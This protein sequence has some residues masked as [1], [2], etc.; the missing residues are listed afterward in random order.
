MK[1]TKRIRAI[2]LDKIRSGDQIVDIADAVGVTRQALY[3]AKLVDEEFGNEWEE[4][5]EI[6]Q[7]IQLS[8]CE[9]ELDFRGRVGWI[10]PK[11]YE[12]RVCGF[13]KKYSDSLLQLRLKALAPEKYKD[14]QQIDGSMN[15]N[16]QGLLVL[17]RGSK[18]AS[19]WHVK[20]T[21]TDDE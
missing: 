9:K 21:Q 4:A 18:T 20:H 5:A 12:G 15:H 8:E 14:R 11:F 13:V 17:E 1:L 3:K 19:E 7:L 2:V 6:G 16:H 10:E